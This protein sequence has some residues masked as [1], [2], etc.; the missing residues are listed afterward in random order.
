[1]IIKKFYHPIS[2]LTDFRLD[3]VFVSCALMSAEGES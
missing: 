2:L 1:M 3:E